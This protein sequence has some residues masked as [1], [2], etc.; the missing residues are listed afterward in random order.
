MC[1]ACYTSCVF[2]DQG[3]ISNATDGYG[4]VNYGT[5]MVGNASIA[6]IESVAAADPSQPWLAYIAPHA[7]HGPCT[8]APWYDSPTVM[9]EG[10]ARKCSRSLCV[11]ERSL[12]K[13][14]LL[15]PAHRTTI[16]PAKI[17]TG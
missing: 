2:A 11:F 8:P 10:R 15:Q 4:G 5:S 14:S 17:T 9:A 3:V 16:S 6:W 1:P 12:K 7:P 13:T